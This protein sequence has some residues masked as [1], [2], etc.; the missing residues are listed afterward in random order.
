MKTTF[1]ICMN[2]FEWCSRLS[3]SYVDNIFPF[4]LSDALVYKAA[5][6]NEFQD[7]FFYFLKREEDCYRLIL[8]MF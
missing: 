8:H 6:E 4:G 5:N 7:Y 3:K 1:K 2:T